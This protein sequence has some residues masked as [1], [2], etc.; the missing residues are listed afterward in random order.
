MLEQS[1]WC[2]AEGERQRQNEVMLQET[3][4]QASNTTERDIEESGQEETNESN[5]QSTQ[6]RC[7]DVVKTSYFCFQR[8]LRLV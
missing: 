4:T 3:E 6:R 8:R 1:L 2:I 7:K 5:A